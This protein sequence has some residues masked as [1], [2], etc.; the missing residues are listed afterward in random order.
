M[1]GFAGA[2]VWVWVGVGVGLVGT[3]AALRFAKVI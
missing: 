2:P 3:V 1:Q